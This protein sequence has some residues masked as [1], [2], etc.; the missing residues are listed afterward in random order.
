MHRVAG[1]A[2]V[3]GSTSNQERANEDASWNSCTE[4]ESKNA[5]SNVT[6]DVVKAANLEAS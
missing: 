2:V 1:E 6:S 5:S 3:K 4:R